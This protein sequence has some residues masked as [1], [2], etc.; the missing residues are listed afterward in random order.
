MEKICCEQGDN[1]VQVILL[2]HQ[3]QRTG[4]PITVPYTQ[5]RLLD[6]VTGAKATVV[7]GPFAGTTGI[8]EVRFVVFKF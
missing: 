1:M 7:S 8:I 2:N 6:L 5:L 3:K 4:S